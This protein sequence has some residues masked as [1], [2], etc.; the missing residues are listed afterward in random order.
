M[1]P[2][3]NKYYLAIDKKYRENLKKMEKTNE[4]LSKKSKYSTKK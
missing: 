1:F 3:V 4:N 2:E